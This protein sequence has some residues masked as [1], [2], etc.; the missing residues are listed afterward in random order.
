M[1]ARLLASGLGFAEGP[2]VMPDGRLVFCDGN[3]GRLLVWDGDEVQTFADVGGS[4]W[5]AV[6]GSDGA[7]YNTQG[8][9]VPGSGDASAVSGIQRV[10]GDGAIELLHTEVDGRTLY[11][12]NDLAFGPD[13][14]LWFT[15]SGSEEDF[16]FDVRSPGRLFAVDGDGGELVLELPGV[17][18]NGIAFDPDGRLYWTESKARRVRRLEDGAPATFCQL[19]DDHIP[20]GMAF[21]R[22]GRA[23]VCTTTSGGVS[24]LSP[25]GGLVGHLDLGEKPTNCCFDGSTLYVTA[26]KIAGIEASQRTG[27]LWAVETDAEGPLPLLPGSL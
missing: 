8:G 5:G 20:D 14:R 7:V 17:Y 22:D 21:A 25:D 13:G 27:T 1:S 2:V 9:N 19:P 26:T 4:P 11:G 15:D 24:V 23:F 16:R 10:R 6:L 18:P 3:V 12:P